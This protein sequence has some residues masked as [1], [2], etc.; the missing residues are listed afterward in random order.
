M[1]TRSTMGLTSRAGVIPLNS[2]AD[3][4]GP[5]A[6]TVEDAARVLQV[7]AG[8]DPDDPVTAAASAHLPSNYTG[9]LDR[10]GLRGTVIG[11][12]HQAYDRT[13]DDPGGL[14]AFAAGLAG[15]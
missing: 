9:A 2:R 10:N 1:G 4:A 14:R 11:V 7:I 15:L 13:T 8:V 5:I 6:R 12:L 3:V